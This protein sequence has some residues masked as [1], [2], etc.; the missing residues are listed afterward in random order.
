MKE[1]N[2]DELYYLITEKNEIAERILYK[3]VERYLR[4][5]AFRKTNDFL[6]PEDVLSYGWQGYIEALEAYDPGNLVGFR[7]FLY[8]CIRRRLIDVQR[9]RNKGSYKAHMTSMLIS[10]EVVQYAV[11]NHRPLYVTDDVVI[12]EQFRNLLTEKEQEV[13]RLHIEGYTAEQISQQIKTSL[14]F[15]YRTIR[16]V[17]K[18]FSEE[19]LRRE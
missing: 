13:L 5:L 7:S 15:V 17:R 16:Q 1:L 10:E 8:H 18:R 14:T 11:E 2:Y 3:D 6:R 12:L 4:Y 19:L 9:R